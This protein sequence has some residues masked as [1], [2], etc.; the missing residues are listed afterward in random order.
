MMMDTTDSGQVAAFDAIGDEW[1]DPHGPFKP[2]HQINPVRLAY[3][4]SKVSLA[5]QRVLDVG[6]GGGLLSEAMVAAGA[7]V[8]GIDLSATSIACAQ[9]HARQQNLSVRYLNI[10]VQTHLVDSEAFYDRVV[11]M[12]LLE[13]LEQPRDMIEACARLVRPGGSVFFS[14]INR[15]LKSYAQ[16]IIGAEYI[17]RWLPRGTHHYDML[18][19][20][21]ELMSW[22]RNVGLEPLDLSGIQYQPLKQR[23]AIVHKP[24]INYILY[25][26]RP[27]SGA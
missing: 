24:E 7:E 21:S 1:W 25:A 22:C 23:F 12:E 14:T 5:D 2:L 20:P 16:A 8:T 13:H 6:C 17:L 15:G 18:I 4:E 27:L 26:V 10:P 19:R 11:C 9:A 3:I